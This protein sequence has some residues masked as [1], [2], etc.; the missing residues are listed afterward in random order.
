[1]WKYNISWT[2]TGILI[3]IAG[4]QFHRISHRYQIKR[5]QETLRNKRRNINAL[6][7]QIPRLSPHELRHT[8]GTA[9]RRRGVDIYTIQQYLGHRDI[10]VT[11]NTY[12]HSEVEA[13]RSALSASSNT[14]T[15]SRQSAP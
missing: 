8:C 11:A 15:N 7:F 6:L 3:M 1:M 10:E 2:L 5:L 13:L 4:I 14:T 12:V 9:L